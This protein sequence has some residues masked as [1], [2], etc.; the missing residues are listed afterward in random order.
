[1]KR[2]ADTGGESVKNQNLEP[3]DSEILSM[4]LNDMASLGLIEFRADPN[5]GAWVAIEQKSRVE[6]NKQESGKAA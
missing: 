4:L 1:M 2:L 6:M 3:T 5:G